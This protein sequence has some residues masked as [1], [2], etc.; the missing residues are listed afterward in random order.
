MAETVQCPVCK[1]PVR[2]NLDG[3]LRK[4]KGNLTPGRNWRS[5]CPNQSPNGT[6]KVDGAANGGRLTTP[7]EPGTVPNSTGSKLP[8]RPTLATRRQFDSFKDRV[9]TNPAAR[10]AYEDAEARNVFIDSLI[11]LRRSKSIT[12]AQIAEDMGIAQATV[13]E[14]ET[15]SSDPRVSTLQRYA[16]AVGVDLV[17]ELRPLDHEGES[18]ATS[19]ARGN[20]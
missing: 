6:M 11:G 12:Q 16:R 7:A 18:D 4:H 14:F 2:V 19:A 1:R 17:L 8:S 5:W 15:E 9:L 3:K 13:S 10:A 20:A